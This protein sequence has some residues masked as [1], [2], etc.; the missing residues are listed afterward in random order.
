MLKV[1][2]TI[3]V[4]WKKTTFYKQTNNTINSISY[5][6]I[7]IQANGIYYGLFHMLNNVLMDVFYFHIMYSN[8]NL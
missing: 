7:S 3:A 2:S 5:I 1:N 4:Y 8:S 6:A